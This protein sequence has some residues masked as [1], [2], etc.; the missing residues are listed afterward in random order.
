[1]II[2]TDEHIIKGWK[3][4]RKVRLSI[5]FG[6]DLNPATT[7]EDVSSKNFASIVSPRDERIR[8][9]TGHIYFNDFRVQ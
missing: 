4:Q 6:P 1:M 9:T 8:L 5:H 2:P 3:H 7:P